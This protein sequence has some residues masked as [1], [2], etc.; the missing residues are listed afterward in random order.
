MLPTVRPAAPYAGPEQD[1]KLLN[2][3]NGRSTWAGPFW[4]AFLSEHDG[5]QEYLERRG[6][7]VT[8][9][10]S[11]KPERERQLFHVS[12]NRLFAS[13]AK[14]LPFSEIRKFF[15]AAGRLE[16]AGQGVKKIGSRDY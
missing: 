8:S 6:L 16:M 14:A 11:Q 10:P 2:R 7:R 15:E 5:R 3:I 12:Y 4:S 1:V 13:R 9:Q